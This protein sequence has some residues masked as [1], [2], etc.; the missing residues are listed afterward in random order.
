MRSPYRPVSGSGQ[1]DR[2]MGESRSGLGG[3]SG[4]DKPMSAWQSSEDRVSIHAASSSSTAQK[5][6]HRRGRCVWGASK[7]APCAPRRRALGGMTVATEIIC[8]NFGKILA[9]MGKREHKY[10][11]RR[12]GNS[13][14]PHPDPLSRSGQGAIRCSRQQL[15]LAGRS[16]TMERSPRHDA[17]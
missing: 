3:Q 16:T 14:V 9:G 11:R 15:D 12:A 5:M 2:L 8:R 17:S 10:N 4:A 1:Q 13:R 6:K 7:P